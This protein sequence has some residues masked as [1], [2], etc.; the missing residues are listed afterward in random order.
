MTIRSLI[1]AVAVTSLSACSTAPQ[2]S[3][4]A[5]VSGIPQGPALTYELLL[6]NTHENPVW[7]RNARAQ[8]QS[9]V[10]SSTQ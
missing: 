3:D 10:P 9:A 7:A 6:P 4:G 1:L 2:R 8:Q 5:A